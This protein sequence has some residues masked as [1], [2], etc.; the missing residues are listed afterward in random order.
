MQRYKTRTSTNDLRKTCPSWSFARYRYSIPTPSSLK[1]SHD[2]KPHYSSPVK[3]VVWKKTI[4]G[5]KKGFVQKRR[6][7]EEEKKG[8][9]SLRSLLG[10][11]GPDVRDTR[12]ERVYICEC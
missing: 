4:V 3:N 7:R 10:I 5:R 1:E 8:R 12:A 11:E 9:A 2:A 6:V